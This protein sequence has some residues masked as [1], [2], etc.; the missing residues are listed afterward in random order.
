MHALG[1]RTGYDLKKWPLPLLV[2]HFGKSG[3]HY[4]NIA[5]G[6]DNRLV[7]NYRPSKSV[8]VEITFQEDIEDQATILQQLYALFDKAL[9]KLAAKQMTAHTLTIK[10]KYHNFVQITRSRTLPQ[11]ITKMEALDVILAD[12]L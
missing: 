8:G 6:I 12:L 1:I 11:A 4:F 7:T 3:H 10:L 5:R 9:T 2:D